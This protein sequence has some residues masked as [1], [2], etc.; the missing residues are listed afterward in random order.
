MSENKKKFVKKGPDKTNPVTDLA[1]SFGKLPPQ[2][3]EAE[4]AVLG[5]LMIEKDA[6]NTIIPLLPNSCY[7]Y[8]E[9]HVI[10]FEAILQVY[11]EKNPTDLLSVTNELRKK[12]KLD[13]IGGPY[14]LVE[15]TQ[16]V[17]SAANLEFHA[18]IVSENYMKRE[19]IKLCSN[20][21]RDAY[22]YG[23]D[24]FDLMDSLMSKLLII[25][26]PTLRKQASSL[27]DAVR[28]A[29]IRYDE[30]AKRKEGV[31]TGVPSGLVA[32]DKITNGW[33]KSDLII[34]AARP[35]MGKTAMVV[36]SAVNAVRTFKKRGFLF[37]LEMS[38]DQ[39][40]DRII[41]TET[42]VELRSLRGR[43]TPDDLLKVHQNI[44]ELLSAN[45]FIDDTPALSI[46]EL[47]A[48][49]HSLISLHGPPDF[50]MVDYLQLMRGSDNERRNGGNREQEIS[51][52]SRGLKAL[53]KELSVP[54]IALSQLSRGVETRGGDK[55]PQLSDLRESGAIEQDADMVAFLYRPEYYK[56]EVDEENNSTLGL[57]E[58]I[59]AKHRNGSLETAKVRFVSQ[60]TKFAN[61]HDEWAQ[62]QPRD[63]APDHATSA[64]KTKY[65][66][67]KEDVKQDVFRQA[68]P[69]SLLDMMPMPQSPNKGNL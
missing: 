37:S 54:I 34:V 46:T 48:K 61:L 64:A 25:Q 65:R 36:T 11:S 10:I 29:L 9:A 43:P 14:Y 31:M 7:F 6:I 67:P 18:M 4:E 52:I 13:Q 56:I 33:Q 27:P 1:M 58:I 47:R 49:T 57:A 3:L 53:A 2:N 60:L 44:G 40:I 55:R 50:I 63:F 45:L 66:E 69:S 20:G 19:L 35:G 15:L 24:V 28:R 26:Q 32:L 22:D 38:T 51:S 30:L 5:A 21:T 17:S 39:L 12:T 42:E 59:I 68:Q 41:S 23:S 16:R 8:K 62:P